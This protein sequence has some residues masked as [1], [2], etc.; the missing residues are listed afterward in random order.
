ME[1]KELQDKAVDVLTA[2]IA[3]S[4]TVS[5]AVL[6]YGTTAVAFQTPAALTGTAFTFEGSIDAGATFKEIR[7]QLGV[8]VSFTVAVDGSYPMDA[9]IFASYDQIKVVSGSA[10]AAER[11][12]LMKPFA[13]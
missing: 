13:L 1:A 4:G 6:L 12:I 5:D 9:S 3:E 8:A 10:E 7:D 11:L 2:T